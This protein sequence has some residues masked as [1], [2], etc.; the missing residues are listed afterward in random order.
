MSASDVVYLAPDK[1]IRGVVSD[2]P[3]KFRV[4]EFYVNKMQFPE[5][6]QNLLMK[7]G[8]DL[9]I[10]LTPCTGKLKFYISD[11]FKNLFKKQSEVTTSNHQAQSKL[12]V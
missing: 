6:D 8:M 12:D 1:A 3:N 10:S 2:N 5:V 7:R 9:F 4:Y 11:D